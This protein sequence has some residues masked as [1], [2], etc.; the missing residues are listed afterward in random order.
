MGLVATGGDGRRGAASRGGYFRGLL[1]NTDILK[2][3]II[4]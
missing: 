3:I 2:I 1:A 4:L